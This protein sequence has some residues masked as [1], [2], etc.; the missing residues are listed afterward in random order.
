L[1]IVVVVIEELK[2]MQRLEKDRIEIQ[3]AFLEDMK[4]GLQQ[5]LLDAYNTGASSSSSSSLGSK[6]KGRGRDGDDD[7]EDD[8]KGKGKG[9]N[10]YNPY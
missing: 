7:D 9:G 2:E 10:R 1:I 3:L 8:N 5:A 6:G 4:V